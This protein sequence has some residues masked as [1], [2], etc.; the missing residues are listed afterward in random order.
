MIVR[1]C[2]YCLVAFLII[3]V[4]SLFVCSE[5]NIS[6]ETNLL[7]IFGTATFERIDV[8]QPGVRIGACVRFVQ[9]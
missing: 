1:N 7:G 9:L 3:V 6:A 2:L 5:R 4:T 8:V